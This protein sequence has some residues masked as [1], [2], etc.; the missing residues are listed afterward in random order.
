[1]AGECLP[2]HGIFSYVDY[3]SLQLLVLFVIVHGI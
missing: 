3:K 2:K 1:M